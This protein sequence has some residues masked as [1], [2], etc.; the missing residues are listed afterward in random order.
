MKSL[1]LIV[2]GAALAFS[3]AGAGW[4]ADAYEMV[5]VRPPAATNPLGVFR[6]NVTSG[7]VFATWGTTTFVPSVEPA[8][9]PAGEY[10][11]HVAET[12]DQKGNWYLYRLDAKSGRTWF[13]TG[14]PAAPV[15]WTEVTEPK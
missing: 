9:L 3:G 13:A 7:Q 8:P 12:L 11:L 15:T 6:I 1:T 5:V 2:L 4:A 14:S 10:H